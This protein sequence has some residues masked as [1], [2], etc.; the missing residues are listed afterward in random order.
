MAQ[1]HVFTVT[2]R[3]TDERRSVG[4]LFLVAILLM[5]CGTDPVLTARI[6]A[7]GPEDPDVPVGPLHRPGQPCVDCH[8]AGSTASPVFSFAGTVY[9]KEGETTPLQ[10]AEVVLTDK[11]GQKQTARTNEAG[12]FFVNASDYS[13]E[14]PV[15]VTVQKDDNDIDM[16]SPI[17]RE[18]SCGACHLP[19]PERD[20]AGPVF[21][22]RHEEPE[23]PVDGP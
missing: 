9:E 16:E 22:I 21:L 12:N 4:Y 20:S 13:P 19:K 11:T 8:R 2:Q 17:F 15:W 5:N 6:A 23:P 10:D 3:K 7:L 1:L 18:G 14:F